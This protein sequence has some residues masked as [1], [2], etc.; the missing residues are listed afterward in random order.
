MIVPMLNYGMIL[1]MD[2]LVSCEPEIDFT[3]Y[4]V[5][6]GDVQMQAVSNQP[7]HV[8]VCSLKSLCKTVW[9]Q[10][11]VTWFGLLREVE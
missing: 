5:G 6:L 7:V 8:D 2:W 1:G 10:K 11:A 4:S 3:Q 9:S